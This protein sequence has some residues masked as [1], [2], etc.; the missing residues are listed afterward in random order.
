MDAVSNSAIAV[1]LIL[2]AL[3]LLTLVAGSLALPVA[4]LKYLFWG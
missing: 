2:F 1:G 3:L 4:A